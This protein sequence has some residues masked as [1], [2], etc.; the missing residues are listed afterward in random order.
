M[1]QVHE[2][3]QMDSRYTTTWCK[4][5]LEPAGPGVGAFTGGTGRCW[6]VS[7]VEYV[8]IDRAEAQ[9]TGRIAWPA[10]SRQPGGTRLTRAAAE[11][12]AREDRTAREQGGGGGGYAGGAG[13]TSEAKV[14]SLLAGP[15]VEECNDGS[16]QYKQ[17]S[18]PGPWSAGGNT[19]AVPRASTSCMRN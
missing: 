11:A 1:R 17:N 15:Q 14:P 13:P 8:P 9:S 2:I 16:A 6:V 5:V 3:C 4:E 18:R 12:A 19:L 10:Q 7:S